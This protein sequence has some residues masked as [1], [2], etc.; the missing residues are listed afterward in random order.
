MKAATL[1]TVLYPP[2]VRDRWGADISDELEAAG[3]RSWPDA[4]AGAA[5][6]WLRPSTW[7]ETF[8]G[9]TRRVTAVALF[10]VT[11][12]TMLVLRAVEPSPAVTADTRHIA[13]SLWL[14][15]TLLG[16]ALAAPLPPPHGAALRRMT[17]VAI[18]VLAGPAAALAALVL[19]ANTEL[20]RQS[21]GLTYAALVA[22]YWGTLAFAAAGMCIFVA[23]VAKAAV[24]PSA[25]RVGAA[26][27]LLGT[28][29][30]CASAQNV[31]VSIRTG[32]V[33]G[34]FAATVAL[35]LLAAATISAGHDLRPPTS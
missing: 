29:L 26:L 16:M 11:S 13:T 6:L 4:V 19:A 31:L 30:A 5:R 18:R 12:V 23:R 27:V 25:R 24:L 2:A 14:A 28:G 7:P 22:Y 15:P 10:V 8:A 34:S 17:A 33:T 1:I 21:T 9:Q 35:T 20:A 32:S 3:P